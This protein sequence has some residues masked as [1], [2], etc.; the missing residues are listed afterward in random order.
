MAD[1]T[2]AA[3]ILKVANSPVFV[4]IT[5][6]E[7]VSQAVVSLGIQNIQQIIFAIELLAVFKGEGIHATFSD[8]E[9]WKHSL[10]GAMIVEELCLSDS[11]VSAETAY[12]AALLRNIGILAIRQY[13]TDKFEAI[14]AL[15][16]INRVDYITASQMIL[17]TN[18]RT[19][20][21]LVVKK[22]KLPE[23]LVT[24]L[25]DFDRLT[26][27]MEGRGKDN[28]SEPCR[29]WEMIDTADALLADW[30]YAQWDKNYKPIAE[31]DREKSDLLREK[32]FAKVEE[33]FEKL[34]G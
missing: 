7:T 1:P 5:R 25:G 19:L 33:V 12:L 16:E 32:L 11:K 31:I 9:F 2:I 27:L 18:H 4:G 6:V 26:D 28:P 10:A 21:Y 20:G 3:Q 29:I 30:N 14:N 23:N 34:W 24:V 15:I 8:R 17:S 22:W 13:L